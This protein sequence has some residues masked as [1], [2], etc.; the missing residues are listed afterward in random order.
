MKFLGNRIPDYEL[1]YSDVFIL[2]ADKTTIKSR[3]EIDTATIDGLGTSTPVIVANMNAVAGKRMAESTARRG[4]MTM[5]LQNMPLERT[6]KVVDYIK[7]RHPVFE[8]PIIMKED[9]KIVAALN[10]IYKR[11]HGSV[12]ITDDNEKPVGVFIESDGHK[13]DRY[14]RLSEVMSRDVISFDHKL[15]PKEMFD[16]LV[17]E[18]IDMAPV[19]NNGKLVGVVTKN[20]LVRSAL[21]KPAVDKQ[22]RLMVGVAVGINEDVEDR[23]KAFEKMGVDAILLDTANGHQERLL[24]ATKIARKASKD[25]FIISGT[26]VTGNATKALIKAGANMVKVGI[27]AGATCITRMRTGVGRPQF[28]AVVECAAA[29]K[30]VGG[31]VMAD[32]GIR[33]PRDVALALAAGAS[34]AMIGSWFAP[35]YESPSD[36]HVD[37]D[38]HLYVENY[39]MA[40]NRAV[41]G[42]SKQEHEYDKLKKAFFEE[43]SSHVQMHL[44]PGLESVEAIIDQIMSG[45]RSTCS[46]VNARNFKELHD[47]AVIGIQSP[48]AFNEG[49]AVTKNW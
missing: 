29:A 46:Y 48:A 28:S 43:G 49:Q 16:K 3:M 4:A 24:E 1:T 30:E 2:P 23:V 22:G 6:K 7:T 18:H 27:G 37:S 47:N 17:A 5:L 14:S 44:K 8:T 38:G 32:A 31:Y 21:H 25:M 11:A 41:L 40:S 39:G 10:L 45:V 35:T 19:T 12:I 15:S 9:D 36:I 33:H 20:G 34:T 26:V 13:E 42:R